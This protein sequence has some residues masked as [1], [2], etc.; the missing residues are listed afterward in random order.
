ME[1]KQETLCSRCDRRTVCKYIES[2]LELTTYIGNIRK[3][4]I[5]HLEIKCDELLK[6]YLKKVVKKPKKEDR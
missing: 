5:H 1:E 6:E 3:A 2:L 4:D